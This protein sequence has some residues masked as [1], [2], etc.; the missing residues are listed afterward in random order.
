MLSLHWNPRETKV[1]KII[2]FYYF[3]LSTLI[4]KSYVWGVL[5]TGVTHLIM[6]LGVF[7]WAVPTKTPLP[8]RLAA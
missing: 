7:W 8:F 4:S 3:Y 5:I 2:I 1:T 6:K